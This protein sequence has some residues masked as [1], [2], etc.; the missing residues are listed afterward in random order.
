[1]TFGICANGDHICFDYCYDPK[2]S[3]PYVVLMYYDDYVTD[4]DDNPKKGI[5]FVASSFE[6]FINMLYEYIDD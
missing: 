4:K 1:M 5:N 3:E 6:E 2:T